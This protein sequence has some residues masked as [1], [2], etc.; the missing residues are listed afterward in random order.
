[1]DFYLQ[2]FISSRNPDNFL[3]IIVYLVKEVVRRGIIIPTMEEINDYKFS[4]KYIV[5]IM[6]KLAVS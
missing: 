5:H 6:L 2:V 4:K 1:M 3:I